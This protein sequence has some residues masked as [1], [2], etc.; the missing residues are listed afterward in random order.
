MILFPPAKINLGLNVLEKRTDGF[1]EI[2]TCMVEIP[3]CDIL[4]ILPSETF[5]FKQTGLTVDGD[6]ESNLCVKAYRLVEER[7]SVD[8][9]Y[10]HLRKNIPMG[11]GLGGGS[12][13]AAYVIKGLNEL[14]DLNI[15]DAEM[16]KLAAELGSDCAFFIKG[17]VQMSTGRGEILSPFDVNLEG[18]YLKLRYPSLHIGTAEAYGGV[19]FDKDCSGYDK[20]GA[21]DFSGLINSFEEYAFNKYPQLEEIKKGYENEGAI[22]A[23]MSGSGSSIFGIYREEPTS[24]AQESEWVMKL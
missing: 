16:E 15:Q 2:K 20:L 5:T 18:F 24:L 17:G 3:F 4:E 6:T 7:Y 1:H 8:P 19:S 12:S 13:D 23:A 14:F 9:V 22:Y 21:L 10:M 11:A